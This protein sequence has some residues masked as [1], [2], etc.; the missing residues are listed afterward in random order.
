MYF[1]RRLSHACFS[2]MDPFHRPSTPPRTPRFVWLLP[3]SR[4]S[5]LIISFGSLS[6]LDS[7]LPHHRPPRTPNLLC[8]TFRPFSPASLILRLPPAV[9]DL[10]P[11]FPSC[12][13]CHYPLVQ[14][15]SRSPSPPAHLHVSLLV[16]CRLRPSILAPFRRANPVIV[17]YFLSL[18]ISA[19]SGMLR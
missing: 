16:L 4:P 18:L 17:A 5:A 12:S 2:L 13:L 14:T 3:V 1:F 10:S 8:P 7:V 6:A 19:L 9:R 11:I 15:L